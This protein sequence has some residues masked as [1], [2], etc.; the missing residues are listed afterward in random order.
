[1]KHILGTAIGILFFSWNAFSQTNYQNAFV[2]AADQ[3]LTIKTVTVAPVTDNVGGIYAKPLDEELRN[4]LNA[5]LQ[6]SLQKYPAD[7]KIK[8]ESL[9][10][11]PEDV[12]K[13]MAASG[14]DAVLSARL[15]KGTRGINGALTLFVGREG[16]PLLQENLVD[17]KGFE[18][19]DVRAQ[20]KR[21]FAQLKAKMP[22]KGIILSRRGQEVTLNLGGSYGLKP[23]MSVSIIQIVKINRHPKLHFM[24]G[25]EKEVLGRVVLTKVDSNLSFGS[26]VFERDPGVVTVGSKV[27]PQEFVKYPSPIVTPDGKILQ[28]LNGRQDKEIAFGDSPQEWLPEAPP[29]FGKIDLLAGFSNYEQ[30]SDLSTGSVSGKNGFAPNILVRGELWL[31]PN[32]FVGL[33]LRQSVFSISNGLSGS[34]PGHLNMAMEQY[35]AGAG[36]NF[37][38][39]NDFFGPKMQIYGGFETTKFTV[40]NSTPLAFTNMEYSGFLLGLSG[41]FPVSNEVPLDLGATFNMWFNPNVSEGSSSGS[42]SNSV[43]TFGFFAD[44][45]LRQRLKIRGELSFEYYKS[46]FSGTGSRPN[47]ASGTSHKLTSFLAGIEYLF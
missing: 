18:T 16:W 14:A 12:Q 34:S 44:Y 23:N 38:L 6:W 47:P 10:D 42:D 31:N 17:Y 35:G 30:S 37:L 41:Q 21:M 11:N 43:N 24:I 15:T 46:D 33:N 45:R 36:Y 13:I 27:L 8:T 4:A 5:D 26:V 3:D 32:W 1:M 22:F 25:T 29:Q 39:S 9:D 19:A 20:F 2:G 28:D 7:L 40:D